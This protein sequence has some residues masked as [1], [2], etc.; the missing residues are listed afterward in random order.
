MSGSRLVPTRSPDGGCGCA[1]PALASRRKLRT[2]FLGQ[3]DDKRASRTRA[4]LGALRDE[5]LPGAELG[6]NTRD[7]YAG[8]IERFIRPAL[9]ALPLSR[10]TPQRIERFYGE[11]RRCDGR[12]FVEHR[13]QGEHDCAKAKCGGARVPAPCA[14]VSARA[15]RH[16]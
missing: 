3:V 1:A 16:P 11:L 5:W 13:R 7:N 9:G 2:K 6:A 15:A 10:V 12:P 14:L 4:S 8:L